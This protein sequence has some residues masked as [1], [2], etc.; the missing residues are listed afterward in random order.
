MAHALIDLI[1][2][3]ASNGLHGPGRLS[4]I[5]CRVL[6]PLQQR[7][8]RRPLLQFLEINLC[9]CV[10]GIDHGFI[11]GLGIAAPDHIVCHGVK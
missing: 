9:G 5:Q 3:A 7:P 2:G 8:V 11:A 1:A 4:T 6:H 10:D